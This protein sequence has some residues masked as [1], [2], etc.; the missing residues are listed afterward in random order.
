MDQIIINTKDLVFRDTI[1]YRDI[2]IIGNKVNFIVGSSGTGKST[3]LR[4]FNGTLTPSSGEVWYQN[5][6][7]ND[8]DTIN[9]RK[10]VLLISQSVFLFDVSIRENFRQFYEYRGKTAP[11]DQIMEEFLALCCVPFDLDKDCTTMSGG[12][13]QRVYIAIFLSF[14]PRVIMLDEPTSAL[15]KENSYKVIQNLLRYCKEKNITVII[16]SHDSGITQE[17]AE[18]IITLGKEDK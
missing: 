9:L 16:V 14:E 17:F 5:K 12:E 15:D 10:E 11:S 1:H 2:Q 18:H 3:L 6:N 7:L 13:R 8:I 4:L